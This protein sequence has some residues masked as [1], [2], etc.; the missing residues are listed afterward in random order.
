MAVHSRC[1][2]TEAVC[3][4][5]CGGLFFSASPTLPQ[6]GGAARSQSAPHMHVLLCMCSN[7]RQFIPTGR[8]LVLQH[9]SI[10]SPGG[11]FF[12]LEKPYFVNPKGI[13]MVRYRKAHLFA[14]TCCVL[15]CLWLILTNQVSHL[16]Q[17]K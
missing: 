7:V 1:L 9:R 2:Q 6:G 16:L 17:Q 4:G 12:A 10:I 5:R 11:L 3:T 15:P 8:C 14:A 13:Y